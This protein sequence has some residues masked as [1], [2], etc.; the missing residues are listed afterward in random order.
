MCAKNYLSFLQR[1]IH[2]AVFATVDGQG[3]P[4]TCV[5][6]V[7]LSDEHGLYFLTARGKAFYARLKAHDTVSVTG[8]RG[9]DTMSS[10]S[11]TVRGK[12]RELGKTLLPEIFERN[13]YMADIY[14]NKES[15]RALTV[16]QIYEG[17]GEFFD[18]SAK[19]I[20]RERF[21]FGGVENQTGGYFVT[22]CCTGCGRCV[23]VCP[24]GCIDGSARPT[25]ILQ[26]HCLHC[27]RC[28]EVCPE[29][30][31]EKRVRL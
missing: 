3:N 20:F 15:R 25:V 5:I 8:F 21:S 31:I 30:A 17:E 27:G 22:E 2:S 13:P 18:L 24:Q 10:Q 19:P 6:D 14:P 16:F 11:V 26:A 23:S 1:D 29:Q 28:A 9:A 4:V 12:V 7:M